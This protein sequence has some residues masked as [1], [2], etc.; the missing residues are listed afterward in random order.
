MSA[1]REQSL[2][3]ISLP[4]QRKLCSV[5]LSLQVSP[6]DRRNQQITT[7]RELVL[8]YSD[9]FASP[10][11]N[12]LTDIWLI[13]AMPFYKKG[14]IQ[15]YGHRHNLQLGTPQCV[16]PG[17]L[18]CCMSYSLTTRLAPCWNKAGPYL[19]S[20]KEF[21]TESGRMN[22]VRMELNASANQICICVE[23][24]TV[25][26]PP[27]KLEDFD[28]P[29]MVL[30][31]FS[32]QMGGVLHTSTGGPSSWCYVLPSMKRGQI[33]SI[34]HQLPIDSPFK[35]YQDL[36]KHWHSLYGYNLPEQRV[37]ETIYCSVYFK[38]VGER[39]FTYPLSC[40]R[41]QPV[42]C[43]PR[44]NLQVAIYPF[45]SDLV[46]RLQSICGLPV[47]MTSQPCYPTSSLT[48]SGSAQV[49][50]GKPVN[51]A[52][53]SAL[54]PVLTQLPTPAAPAVQPSFGLQ[55][56]G[57]SPVSLQPGGGSLGGRREDVCVGVEH[58]EGVYRSNGTPTQRQA[59]VQGRANTF[60][61]SATTASSQSP[62]PSAPPLKLVPVFRN[63]VLT[64]HVD[65]TQ[66]LAQ[67]QENQR[68][69]G[70]A[71]GGRATL[72]TYTNK[73]AAPATSSPSPSDLCLAS[74]SS[75]S[76]LHSSSFVWSQRPHNPIVPPPHSLPSFT[77]R[78]KSREVNTHRLTHDRPPEANPTSAPVPNKQP[79]PKMNPSAS[80]MAAVKSGCETQPL[81]LKPPAH[82][83]QFDVPSDKGGESFE[84]M[85]KRPKP[86]IQEVDVEW[87]AKNNQLSK[88]NSATL[89]AWLRGRGVAVRVKDKKTELMLRVMGCLGDLHTHA[90]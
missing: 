58:E 60:S 57:R 35:C 50:D 32:S 74:S 82:V 41:L 3:F 25:T 36:Q 27:T 69:G 86:K 18:Q 30:R 23:A 15:A 66:L 80:K 16:L 90:Q 81:T 87:M 11:L 2:F 22:A 71:E 40:I 59:L 63:R 72:A 33:I 88:V 79:N 19:L 26:L 78:S 53:R 4:D 62:S 56:P 44:D 47:R 7:C 65:V 43:C 48:S 9:I 13:M 67:E 64:R 77:H 24:N 54:H 39:L 12:S 61:A 55:L 52:T 70:A 76:S 1:G 68:R 17:I 46:D 85:P 28:F 31:S 14:I 20:G 8:L 6:E 37:E 34:S 49:L 10:A 51:L 89:L 75:S 83:V 5:S 29:P 21:L 42:H 73:R 38:L 45:I 84:S